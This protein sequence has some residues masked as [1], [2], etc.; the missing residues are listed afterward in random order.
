MIDLEIDHTTIATPVAPI[1]DFLKAYITYR[2]SLEL[3]NEELPLP[4]LQLDGNTSI[5]GNYIKEEKLSFE[6][7]ICLCLAL[8]PHISPKFLNDIVSDFLPNGG[9][10][11]EFGGIKG[12]NHRG[13]LP[14]AETAV[15]ILAGNTIEKRIEV[16]TSLQTSNYEKFTIDMPTFHC[17]SRKYF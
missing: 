16:I 11:P 14:T 15:Y 13:I 10:F 1:F 17:L 4:V 12:K 6:E 9:E 2:L 5:L 3:L 7:T 8:I